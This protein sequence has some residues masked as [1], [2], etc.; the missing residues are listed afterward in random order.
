MMT[1]QNHTIPYNTILYYTILYYTIPK[2]NLSI[3]KQVPIP[4]LGKTLVI[5]PSAT[6]AGSS[7]SNIYIDNV[8]EMNAKNTLGEI[9]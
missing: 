1:T 6:I 8:R 9:T 7:A 3:G 5:P 2:P 4:P